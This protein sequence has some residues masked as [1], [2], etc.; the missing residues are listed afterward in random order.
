MKN[1][2]FFTFSASILSILAVSA[3]IFSS[4]TGASGVGAD[5]APVTRQ[6]PPVPLEGEVEIQSSD[7]LSVSIDNATTT[8]Y[9]TSFSIKLSTGEDALKDVDGLMSIIDESGLLLETDKRI[10]DMEANT[11]RMEYYQQ[12]QDG[13]AESTVVPDC[14]IYSFTQNYRSSLVVPRTI[15]RGEGGVDEV[16]YYS[17]II[18][19]I[20]SGALSAANTNVKYLYIPDTIDKIP[21]DAFTGNTS[22]LRIYC[23]IDEDKKPD[24]WID[25]WNNGVPVTWSYDVY[26]EDSGREEYENVSYAKTDPVGDPEINYIAGYFP[27]D[28][29]IQ[30]RPVVVEYKLEGSNEI[31]YKALPKTTNTNIYDGVGKLIYGYVNR[32]NCVIDLKYGEKIDYDS[33]VI[34][35]LYKAIE[36]PQPVGNAQYMPDISTQYYIKPHKDFAR[37]LD[38]S[39]FINIKFEKVVRFGNYISVNSTVDIVDKGAILAEL[40]PSIIKE[41]GSKIASGKAY[42]RT[43]FTS[44]SNAKYRMS[45]DGVETLTKVDTHIVQLVLSKDTGNRVNFVLSKD[46]FVGGFDLNK[47]ESFALQNFRISLDVVDGDTIIKKTVSHTTFGCVYFYTPDDVLKTF[48]ANLL[49]ILLAAGYS[50]AAAALSTFLFFL[51]KKIY[52]NDE[53]RRLKPKQFIKKAIIYSLTSLAV[54]LFIAFVVLRLSL[55]KNAIIVY[56]P[57]DVFI[58]F[59]GIATIIIIGYYVKEIAAAVKANKQR[60][61]AIKLGLGN[62]VAD[63]GTK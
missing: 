18:N 16:P 34:H 55:F 23:E 1:K 33:I 14:Y 46:M 62:D 47:F 44:L 5:N 7:H 12:L 38:I 22:L 53:F 8:K 60:K 21:A 36:D 42:I 17:G 54:V 20:G 30:S 40:K 35:N 32:L 48:D 19:A 61:K 29:S 52:K 37:V 28:S 63:D 13:T 3:S 59:L 9:G 24:E 49:I 26:E 39:Q 4:R 31:Y 6:T 11:D 50:V 10:S 27:K 43:R 56:N 45:V 15:Y 58:V 51:Y 57:L 2:L 25:G 41:F